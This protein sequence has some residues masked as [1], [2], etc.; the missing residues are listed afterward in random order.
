MFHDTTGWKNKNIKMGSKI[1]NSFYQH[2]Q[3]DLIMCDST[4][5]LELVAMKL[6]NW[7]N[8]LDPQILKNAVVPA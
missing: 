7:I 1:I 3:A 8:K 5:N 2:F 4:F 6:K